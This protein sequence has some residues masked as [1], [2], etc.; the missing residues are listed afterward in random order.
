MAFAAAFPWVVFAA[1]LLISKGYYD[2]S[3]MIP[4]VIGSTIGGY[5]GSKFARY[6]GN[7]FIKIMYVI[8]GGILGLKL[9]FGL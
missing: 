9:V 5:I 1:A 3:V 4:A 8:F 7:H 6:K 2:V